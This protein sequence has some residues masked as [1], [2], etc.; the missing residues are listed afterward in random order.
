M[1]TII[2]SP[3]KTG[4][5]LLTNYLGPK[6]DLVIKEVF[7]EDYYEAETCPGS[8]SGNWFAWQKNSPG[9]LKYVLDFEKC[10]PAKE[11]CTAIAKDIVQ[12]S[13]GRN[14]GVCFQ[15]AESA[16]L[17]VQIF[18]EIQKIGGSEFK[19]MRSDYDPDA[20]SMAFVHNFLEGNSYFVAN[21]IIF[22][23]VNAV[24]SKNHISIAMKKLSATGMILLAQHIAGLMPIRLVVTVVK[25]F[26]TVTSCFDEITLRSIEV[27][28]LPQYDA[29]LM[30]ERYSFLQSEYFRYGST[31][32][33]D[34][35]HRFLN[36]IEPARSILSNMQVIKNMAGCRIGVDFLT[37]RMDFDR[38]FLANIQIA[39]DG[40]VRPLNTKDALRQCI[41]LSEEI[42]II[43]IVLRGGRNLSEL[44]VELDGV[45]IELSQ[46][47]FYN[48][49][50]KEIGEISL[51]VNRECIA[52]ICFEAKCSEW[53]EIYVVFNKSTSNNAGEVFAEGGTL[54]QND[55]DT[56]I[57]MQT[58]T[59][60]C[61]IDLFESLPIPP[62]IPTSME[63]PLPMLIADMPVT[64]GLLNNVRYPLSAVARF[65]LTASCADCAP[66]PKVPN[67][68]AV[69]DE[70][71]V[72]VQQMHDGTRVIAGGYYGEWMQSLIQ[73]LQ[74]HHEPQEELV[75]HT[76]LKYTRP[77]SLM[78]ELGCSW[79]Y[80][81]NWFLGAVPQSKVVCIEPDEKRMRVGQQ[82][83]KLN[84]REAVFH[85]AAAGGQFQAE[86]VFVRESDGASVTVPVWDFGKLQEE[87]GSD[88]IELLHMDAQGAELPFLQSIARTQYRG[89]L[90]FVVIST[91]HESISGSAVTHRDC[92]QSLINMGAF[93]L[94]EHA[95][96]ESFSGDGLIVA[97]FMAEDVRIPVPHISRCRPEDSLF[98]PDP[99]RANRQVPDST[100]SLQPSDLLA[101]LGEQVEVVQTADG[102]MHIFKADLV[103]GVALKTTGTFQTDKIDE[104]LAF[105]QMRFGFMCDLFVDIGG[106][107]GTHLV[108]ALKSCGF[109]R[110]VTFEPDPLNNAL[111]MQNI[112]ENGL[113]DRVRAFKLALSSRSG[114]TTFEL[115][116][117]NF[118]DHRV[119]V[120]DVQ[121]K[122]TFGEDMRQV[123]SVLTDTGDEFFEE[124][125]LAFSAKTLIWVDTQGHEG[126][127]FTGF[128]KLFSASEKPF[129]VC[130]FWPYGLERAGGKEMFFNFLGNCTVF[131]DINQENWQEKPEISVERLEKLYQTML[132]DTRDG[133]YPH[134]D[135]L[136]VL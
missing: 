35:I 69:F 117:S 98:G 115:C 67:S 124:N 108:H 21:A 97:S 41:G 48:N 106:N 129:V 99:K 56:F 118:G 84:H 128:R 61:G 2:Y 133:H 113:A 58:D 10:S 6:F 70:D 14:A 87:I 51:C 120:A 101:E 26:T 29:H 134:T 90:R 96:D 119:R 111:L 32:D 15:V 8:L 126:H 49:T 82:N 103:I 12:F 27:C 17:T 79:A 52:A 7:H 107:I 75:F 23:I 31:A 86:Q 110:G 72:A 125:N 94:C 88:S 91:H 116:G 65:E 42:Y 38:S 33:V 34:E 1:N 28:M 136:C 85:L 105:L 112:T 80:Y 63:S 43:K 93:I 44:S 50:I 4:S 11:W 20:Q 74:G 83:I 102:P 13:I 9:W 114:S 18:N 62:D 64:E 89:R 16:Q 71:G 47:P 123:I 57:S 24:D 39:P 25:Y 95:V 46:A 100:G 3:W 77:G 130:E 53:P 22:F 37:A 135:I 19:L 5:T 73:R 54:Y 66:L 76:L 30:W 81:S 78:V 55:S 36:Y 122:V 45:R 68:G 40:K 109:I 121:P 59:R 92:L 131:Y 127:V 132:A 104:V 60:V